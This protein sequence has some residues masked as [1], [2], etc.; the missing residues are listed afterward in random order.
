[1]STDPQ[2]L[3]NPTHHD[4]M[5]LFTAYAENPVG[6][7]FETQHEEEKVIIFMRQHFVLNLPWIGATILL[8]AAPFVIIPFLWT[9]VQVPFVIPPNYSFIALLFWYLVTFGYALMNFIRWYYNI[10]I[11][12]TE[13]IID[14]DFIQL[15]YKKFSEARLENIEDVTYVMVGFFATT[16]NYGNVSIQTAAETTQFEFTD[17]PRPA[18]VVEVI[19]RLVGKESKKHG[20]H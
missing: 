14:I 18:H 4:R 5:S 2:P 8:L 9:F 17:I 15:L 6:V 13:R 12:T 16:F 10:Y 11:V 19:S 3:K 20:N 1:M 7:T